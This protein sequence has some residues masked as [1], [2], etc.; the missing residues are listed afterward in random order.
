MA[1]KVQKY[2]GD[3]VTVYFDPNRCMH[4]GRCVR[5]LPEVFDVNRRPWIIPD[6]ADA[7]TVVAMVNACPSGALS[8]EKNGKH[9]AGSKP[10]KNHVTVM[11]DGPLYLHAE[12]AINGEEQSTCRAALCRCGATKNPPYCDGEHKTAGFK[13]RA[14]SISGDVDENIAVDGCLEIVSIKDG[15]LM[16]RGGCEVRTVKGEVVAKSEESFFCRCG[17]SENKPFCDGSHNKIGF[18]SK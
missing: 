18:R 13:D 3:K 9:Q 11:P 2:N 5:E 10:D 12:M 15:P 14:G 8:Y 7:E 4:A 16:V 17:A 6:A 1:K